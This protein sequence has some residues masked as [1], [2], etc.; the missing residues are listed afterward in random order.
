MDKET[1][2]RLQGWYDATLDYL[3]DHKGVRWLL[4]GLLAGAV[5]GIWVG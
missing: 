5:F 4:I 3:A 1:K 2:A